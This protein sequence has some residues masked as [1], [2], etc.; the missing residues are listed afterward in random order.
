MLLPETFWLLWSAALLLL[1]LSALVGEFSLLPWI[2]VACVGAGLA[3]YLGASADAQ[4][5]WFSVVLIVS[6][7]GSRK[8]FRQGTAKPASITESA[9][10]MLGQELTVSRVDKKTPQLGE[11]QS[12]TGKTWRIEHA[13]GKGLAEKNRV[14][15]VGIRGI[16]LIVE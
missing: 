5:F 8:L 15:C 12:S 6:V 2:A 13:H 10:E 4:L 16:S 14:S 11:G 9:D 7:I 3:N 1:A